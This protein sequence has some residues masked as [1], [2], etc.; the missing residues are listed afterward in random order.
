MVANSYHIISNLCS[1]FRRISFRV[2]FV[3]LLIIIQSKSNESG[4]EVGV[5]LS[6]ITLTSF[7]V[8]KLQSV[9]G[10]WFHLK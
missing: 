3:K 4:V 6:A 7:W 8:D 9:V 1:S 2:W 5:K 10:Q